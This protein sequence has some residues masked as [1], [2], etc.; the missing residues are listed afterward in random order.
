MS[1]ECADPPY[2]STLDALLDTTRLLWPE[3]ALSSVEGPVTAGHQ[4]VREFLLLPSKRQP[5]LALPVHTPAVAAEVLR[6][7]SQGLT[8]GERAARTT[9]A[10]LVRLP[11]VNRGLT[12]LAR[13]RLTVTAPSDESRHSLELHLAQILDH[14]VV[15]G[16]NLGQPRA[17]RKPVLHVLAPDGRTLA[18]V[19]VGTSAAT[20]HLVRG[21]AQALHGFWSAGPPSGQLRVPRVLHHGRWRD[22]ELLVL[23]P[24]RPRSARWRRPHVPLAAMSELGVHLGTLGASF[25]DTPAWERARATP[26]TLRNTS[27]A[28]QLERILAATETRHGRTHVTVGTWHG[29]WT[30]WN[31]AW[32]DRQVLLWDFERFAAGVPLG[33]DLAH[34]RLQ[35]ALRD[36]GEDA[37]ARLVRAGL[38]AS[39]GSPGTTSPP[40][41]GAP[42]TAALVTTALGTGALEPLA[43]NDPNAVAVG[44]LVEL[45]CRYVIAAAP[46]EGAPLRARTTWLLGL[47]DE[48]VVRG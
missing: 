37:A 28:A 40:G 9:A 22:L 17:N 33:F 8:F 31:M 2:M 42:G 10:A 15:V 46:P 38:V 39:D 44:Y 34:Y 27:Q 30:P 48:L 36:G 25:D 7:Y 1:A 12:R 29:D 32:D 45:A 47:L 21:E 41:S 24:L 14:E 19:K 16:V 13:H 18:Y 4:V 35:S 43:G 3:P 11:G 26:G 5:R 20:A 23:D 6:K